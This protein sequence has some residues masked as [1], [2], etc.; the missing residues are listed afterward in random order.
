MGRLRSFRGIF[1]AHV[2][3][4][5]GFVTLG[6]LLLFSAGVFVGRLS[7]DGNT[8]RSGVMDALPTILPTLTQT[9]TVTP[10]TSPTPTITPSPTPSLTQS[11]T[12]TQ[13]QTITPTPTPTYTLTPSI[14]PT[15]TIAASATQSADCDPAY[16]DVCI[17]SPPP[18]LDCKDI[19]DRKFRVLPP[20]PHNFDGDGNGIGC[21]VS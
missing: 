7:L 19:P 12:T 18:D 14:T 17:P 16:P 13:T 3:I 6:G 1:R 15:P 9:P 2:A 8:S 10:T 4:R 20:D 21:E 11:P 5:W